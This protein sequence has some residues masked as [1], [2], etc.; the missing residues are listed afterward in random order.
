[1]RELYQRQERVKKM[2]EKG[3]EEVYPKFVK[4]LKQIEEW[5]ENNASLVQLK[6]ISLPDHTHLQILMRAQSEVY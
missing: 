2:I 5:I 4:K 1:M 3:G 6:E